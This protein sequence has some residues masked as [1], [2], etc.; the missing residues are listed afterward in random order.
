MRLKIVFEFIGDDIVIPWSY[1]NA[2]R[3][4]VFG[5]L[6]I[7]NPELATYLHDLGFEGRGRFY[8]LLTFSLLDFK[9]KKVEKDGIRPFGKAVWYFSSPVSQIVEAIAIGALTEQGVKIGGAEAVVW[10]IEVEESKEIGIHGIF[11]T[12]SPICLSTGELRGEKLHKKFLEPGDK[13]YERVLNANLQGK[14]TAF[15]GRGVEGWVE[16]RWIREP[17]SKMFRI[18]NTDVRGWLGELEL[19][20]PRDLLWIAYEAGVGEHTSSGFGMLGLISE[21]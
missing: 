15:W 20:G 16:L 8:K 17:R 11:K 21:P 19:R 1:P 14:A 10:S 5:W 9:G 13:D 12:L 7:G 18:R 2:L 3:G 4:K 6:R